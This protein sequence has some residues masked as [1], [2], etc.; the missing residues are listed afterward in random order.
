MGRKSSIT[1]LEPRILAQVNFLLTDGDWTLDQVV[2]YLK[3]AGPGQAR[4]RSALDRY[5][6]KIAAKADRMKQSRE[7][8]EVLG[9]ELGNASLQGKQ[10]RLLV[11]MTRIQVFE[12]LDKLME[13]G[14]RLDAKEIALLGKGLAELARA[15]RFDQDFE[16]KIKAA[17]LEQLKREAAAN[18][19][20]ATSEGRLDPKAAEEARKALGFA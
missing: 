16:E 10:G 19:D 18:L 9:R 13:E 17:A 14:G 20:T 8:M 12:F 3:D 2:D 4:S 15:G 6:Q 11:E 7:V 1:S 5:R